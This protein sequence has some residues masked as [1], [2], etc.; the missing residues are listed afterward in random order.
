MPKE[1]FWC[2]TLGEGKLEWVVHLN[3]VLNHVYV[4]KESCLDRKIWV[5]MNE[6]V[7]KG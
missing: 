7:S 5:S 1:K 2:I 3:V 6:F 4:V